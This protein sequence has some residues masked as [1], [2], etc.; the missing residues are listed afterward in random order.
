MQWIIDMQTKKVLY[1]YV[2]KKGITLLLT[3]IIS[4]VNERK[5]VSTSYRVNLYYTSNDGVCVSD[6]QFKYDSLLD[7]MIRYKDLRKQVN[8]IHGI[9]I[10]QQM[11][12]YVYTYRKEVNGVEYPILSEV[13][14]HVKELSKELLK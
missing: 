1:K 2:P 9:P 10:E 3:E 11:N 14:E 12:E 8:L 6:N 5:H 7:A 4:K 13:S